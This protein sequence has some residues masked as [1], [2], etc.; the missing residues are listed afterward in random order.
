MKEISCIDVEPLLVKAIDKEEG[1]GWD[2]DFAISVSKEYLKFLEL[3]MLN[4]DVSIVPSSHV[5]EFW[6][7]HILDTQKYYQDCE[8]HLGFFLHHFPYFGMRGKEDEANLKEAWMNTKEIYHMYYGEIPDP[9]I[10]QASNRC[11]NCGRRC[12]NK[13]G[14]Y[15]E[16][17][18]T[19]KSEGIIS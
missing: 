9:K 2:L 10:W 16:E 19:L 12:S 6:H 3:C 17:R 7:L 13:N 18:P 1:L 5:D 11:P 8:N 15:F 4:P 14:V